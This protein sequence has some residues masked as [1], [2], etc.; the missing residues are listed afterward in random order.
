MQLK[1]WRITWSH[2]FISKSCKVIINSGTLQRSWFLF[3]S[4]CGCWYA[5]NI[6]LHRWSTQVLS[7]ENGLPTR[8][9]LHW[10]IWLPS[11]WFGIRFV[12]HRAW[13]S[14]TSHLE[15]SENTPSEHSAC[16][17]R[18]PFCSEP[19]QDAPVDD[20]HG[21]CFVEG[22]SWSG[23]PLFV[24]EPICSNDRFIHYIQSKYIVC[25]TEFQY[26]AKAQKQAP[27][28]QTIEPQPRHSAPA[29]NHPPTNGSGASSSSEDAW[30]TT[31]G[32]VTRGWS[33]ARGGWQK[34]YDYDEKRLLKMGHFLLTCGGGGQVTFA[35]VMR[36]SPG[37][38]WTNTS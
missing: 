22:W 11:E 26:S 24:R 12:L 5:L 3:R 34:Q 33:W 27:S 20:G 19:L 29:P 21:K 6:W 15:M 8:I 25:T 2:Q 28:R 17:W 38:T 16:S 18:G 37:D 13:D 30:P 9:S 7:S 31:E 36:R 35:R 4:C 23:L 32:R 1:Q 10:L 14:L